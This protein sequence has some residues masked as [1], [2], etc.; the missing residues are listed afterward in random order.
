MIFRWIPAPVPRYIKSSEDFEIF[1]FPFPSL[2][3]TD[4]EFVYDPYQHLKGKALRTRQ[5][6][7]EDLAVVFLKPVYRE[8]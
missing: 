6:G 3:N 2:P 7:E 5:S 8:Q 1:S 4:Y